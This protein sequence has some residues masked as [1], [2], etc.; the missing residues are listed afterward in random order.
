M[1]DYDKRIVSIKQSATLDAM[2][3]P[4]WCNLDIS[5]TQIESPK[6]SNSP[7]VHTGF[8]DAKGSF[9]PQIK[10]LKKETQLKMLVQRKEPTTAFLDTEVSI[11]ASGGPSMTLVKDRRNRNQKFARS[12]FHN[13][14]RIYF[15]GD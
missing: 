7:K 11:I 5:R 12:S 2:K 13:V 8:V 1:S 14:S 6:H 15:K 4:A 3:P 9:D 10:L